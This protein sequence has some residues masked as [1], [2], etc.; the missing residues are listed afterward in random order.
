VKNW[1]QNTTRKNSSVPTYLFP[2]YMEWPLF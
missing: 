2:G 1:T